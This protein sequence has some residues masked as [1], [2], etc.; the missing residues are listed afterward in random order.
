MGLEVYMHALEW[1]EWFDSR[2][3]CFTPEKGPRY[4]L[5]GELGWPQGQ[6]VGGD[7]DKNLVYR[8]SNLGPIRRPVTTLTALPH[9]HI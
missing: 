4:Q 7:E 2:P 1:D 5:D 9:L 3:D 8:Q 6:P